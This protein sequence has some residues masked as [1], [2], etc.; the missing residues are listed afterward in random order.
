MAM[1]NL[2]STINTL[3]TEIL[4]PVV[5]LLFAVAV[6]YFIYGVIVYIA[7]A[8]DEDARREG[9]KHMLYSIIGL[10]I[11]AGVWG[12]IDLIANTIGADLPGPYSQ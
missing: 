12:I 7:N 4:N 9:K 1:G 2:E 5:R 11:M 10:V 8:D 3:A 6:A